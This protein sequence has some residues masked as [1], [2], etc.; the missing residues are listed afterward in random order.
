MACKLERTSRVKFVTK[1]TRYVR[2]ANIYLDRFDLNVS[3]EFSILRRQTRKV[4]VFEQ[5]WAI[6]RSI[7]MRQYLQ[8]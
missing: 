6:D 5:L 3:A 2:R 4:S 7:V 1:S 8:K